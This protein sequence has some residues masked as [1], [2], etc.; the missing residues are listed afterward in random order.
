MAGHQ[1]SREVIIESGIINE[2]IDEAWPDEDVSLL[3]PLSQ[4]I[5]RSHA[6]LWVDFVNKKMVPPFYQ[7]LQRQEKMGQDEATRDLL[8]SLESFTEAMDPERPFLYGGIHG[9]S[10]HS[11]RAVVIEVLHPE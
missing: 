6:R 2:F 9:F 7:L 8:A 11:V 4:P 1:S 3:P 5:K 10:G